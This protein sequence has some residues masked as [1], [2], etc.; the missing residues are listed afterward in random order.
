[1]KN[2]RKRLVLTDADYFPLPEEQIALLKQ[3]NIELIE[4]PRGI[5]D[6]ALI[7]TCSEVDGVLVFGTRVTRPVIE[8]MDR[9][10]ILARCGIGYDN[11]DVAAA[12]EKGIIVTY[13]PDYCI[14][15]VSDHTIGLMLDAV[16]RVSLS[17]DRVKQGDWGSYESLGE[18]RRFAGSRVGL[19]GFGQIARATARKLSTFR[20]ELLSHDPYVPEEAMAALGVR[21]VS[22]DELMAEA[23][24][25]VLLAPLTP[26]TKHIINRRALQR[27]KRGS[28]LINT[29]RGQLV[30]EEAL[31]W[32]LKE[33]IVRAAGLDVLEQEPPAKD[34]PL[35]A[36]PQ[37]TITPH[38]A[39]FSEESLHELTYRAIQEAILTF[40]GMPPRTQVPEQLSLFKAVE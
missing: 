9:C 2:G 26:G 29:S 36:M 37:V 31:I 34:H 15:E 20:I 32:A 3:E 30:E 39:A 1:M 8:A 18:I 25:L 10:R 12:S 16:R 28:I 40:R 33:G 14:E 22:F 27:M 17:R 4:I 11:I 35:F 5:E 19:L 23:D 6:T 38:S 24:I 21:K 13:V 7:H